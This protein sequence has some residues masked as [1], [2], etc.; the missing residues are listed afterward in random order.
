MPLLSVAQTPYIGYTPS[1]LEPGTT[2][3]VPVSGFD[4]INLATGSL[5]ISLPLLKI[6]GRGAAG[7]TMTLQVEKHWWVEA[8]PETDR[9]YYY[10]KDRL[11]TDAPL[12]KPVGLGPGLLVARQSKEIAPGATCNST[13]YAKTLTRLTFVAPDGSET[14]FV[15][16]IYNG[17]PRDMSGCNS[18]SRGTVW[19]STDGSAMTFISD[20]PIFD[21]PLNT[22]DLRTY[23]GRL[24]MRDG[25]FYKINS[26][27]LADEIRDRNGNRV[28]FQYDTS[29]RVTLIRDSINREVTVSYPSS[30]LI[31]I[32][33]KSS[34]DAIGNRDRTI[35]IDYTFPDNQWLR[36]GL[37]GPYTHAQAFPGYL[38][39][40]ATPIVPTGPAKVTLPDGRYYRFWYNAYG[41]V[42]RID[43]PT[44]GRYE[45]DWKAGYGAD[46]YGVLPLPQGIFREC[47]AYLN[48]SDT[49]SVEQTLYDRASASSPTVVRRVVPN[50]DPVIDIEVVKHYFHGD[51]T[52]AMSPLLPSGGYSAA[53]ANREYKT[54]YY[55]GGTLKRVVENNWDTRISYSWASFDPRVT[56]VTTTL[57]D[58]SPNLVSKV[59]HVYDDYNNTTITREY[60]FGS[61]SPGSLLRRTETTYLTTNPNQNNTNYATDT[62]IHIRS[63][64]VQVS[65]YDGGGTERA[66]TVFDYD[67]YSVYPLEGYSGLTMVQHDSAY[68]ANYQKRG[69]ATSVT[70]HAVIGSSTIVTRS[71]F[72]IGGN[73]IKIVDP[74]E[75]ATDFDFSDNFGGLQY[76]PLPRPIRLFDTRAPIPGFNACAYLNQPLLAGQELARQVAGV[77]CD[78][79]TIPANAQAIVGNA[80]VTDAMGSGFITL[81]PNGQPRPSVSNLNY[82]SGQTVPNAFTVSLG[83]DGMFRTF[84][85][86]TTHFIVDVTGYFAPP[87][88][89]GLYYHPLPRPIR[90][91]DTRAPIQGFA[92]CEY[93][94]QPL[95]ADAELVKQAR[96]TCDGITIPADAT[97]IVGNATVTGATGNGFI[98]LF[99]DGQPRPP[100]SNLNYTTGQTVPNA[101]TVGLGSNGQFRT[102]ASAGTHF[103]VDITGY[104]SPSPS[105]ANGAGLLYN[106]LPQ[107]IR[108]FDTRAPIQGFAACEYLDQPLVAD[109]ELVKQARITCDGITIPADAT[110]IVGNATV[111]GA[112]GNGF[113]TLF[114]DGQPRPPVSNLNYTTGQTVPNAFTVGLGSNGQFR[115]YAS[116]GTHFIV[117]LTGYFAPPYLPSGQYAFAFPTRTTNAVGHESF[118]QYDYYLGRPIHTQDANGVKTSTYYADALDRI[119]KQISAVGLPAQ[120][121]TFYTYDDA[122]RKVI[123]ETDQSATDDRRLKIVSKYDGLGRVT[124]TAKNEDGTNW[125]IIDTEYDGLGR[126]YRVSNP[127][128]STNYDTA[129]TPDETWTMTGFDGLGRLIS[130]QTPDGATSTLTYS[131]N[132]TTVQDPASRKRQMVADALGRV[133]SVV[134]DPGG[135]AEATTTYVYNVFDKVVQSTQTDGSDTQHRYWLYD[136]LSRLKAARYPEQ[137]APHSITDSVSGNNAWSNVYTYDE[138]GNVAEKLDPRSVTTYFE[139][140]DINRIIGTGYSDSTAGVS[141]HYDRPGLA[142]GKG[143]LDYAER[144]SSINGVGAA[145][146]KLVVDI[147]DPFGRVKKQTTWLSNNSETYQRS[148]PVEQTYNLAGQVTQIKYPS[149]RTVN[150]TFDQA[151]RVATMNGNLG[152][153]QSNYITAITYNPAHQPLKESWGTNT[154]LYLNRHYNNRLQNYDIRLGTSATD[155]WEWNRGALRYYYSSNY[156]WGDGGTGNNGNLYRAEHFIPLDAAVNEWVM[157]TQYYSYDAF[158]RLAQ[159]EEFSETWIGGSNSNTQA[160]KQ[161]YLYDNFG[162]RRVDDVNSVGLINKLKYD[163][164]KATNRVGVPS[165]QTGTITYDNAGNMVYDSYST[166][167]GS[168]NRQFDGSSRLTRSYDGGQV[169]YV[170]D[171]HGK[172]A[173]K[174]QASTS[175]ETWYIYGIGGELL[176]EYN[177]NTVATSPQREYAYKDGQLLIFAAVNEN[178]KWIVCDVLGTPRM[179]VDWW[180]DL[181]GS[182]GIQRHDYLPFGEELL[183]GVGVR[184]TGRGYPSASASGKGFTEQYHD[185]ETG[186]DYFGARYYNSIT[187]RFIS[188]DPYDA[189][190]QVAQP[191]GWNRYSYVRNQPTLHVDPDGMKPLRN[192]YRTAQEVLREVQRVANRV[193]ILVR[194]DRNARILQELAQHYQRNEGYI[195]S[196]RYGR[197]IDLNHFFNAAAET[198]APADLFGFRIPITDTAIVVSGLG[199][200]V[201]ATQGLAEVKVNVRKAIDDYLRDQLSPG[202]YEIVA[203]SL[204]EPIEYHNN[205]VGFGNS[206]FNREDLFS[207][208]E[209]INW[210]VLNARAQWERLFNY[211]RWLDIGSANESKEDMWENEKAR[212]A[213]LNKKRII[214]P[215]RRR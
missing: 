213:D 71:K 41:E 135:A 198:A 79:I 106:P 184:A 130:T 19:Y 86:A 45:Y 125:S 123:V 172:R 149:A 27:G 32:T 37:P 103:I 182:V 129:T 57:T 119:T 194:G 88:A 76:Y 70:R 42:A 98:T 111:T 92:A 211:L 72:D 28:T 39:P 134:L 185:S 196:R 193:P 65:V 89:G 190:S 24:M 9:T 52:A 116:A 144:R 53:L 31:Q 108:L 137:A 34:P 147:F 160:F 20:D 8:V 18:F 83:A 1:G 192:R 122:N 95:V 124:R 82:T 161:V 143:R 157:A 60:D 131:G 210:A 159:V 5:N 77:T 100:V 169:D 206:A 145:Y 84:S 61:G 13:V 121:Q 155:E 208:Q 191:Q 136:S 22:N 12:V 44:G 64:P 102:Y 99:P 109:A 101:F 67:N 162:N 90:L 195:Y 26:N 110:A 11:W 151:G 120:M 2:S 139:Y 29:R 14:T 127:Y 215:V 212:E 200:G 91:F 55:D 107:P 80:T 179:F 205:W 104:Y 132:A 133:T 30:T 154:A 6:G 51:P 126:A 209:G 73:L 183:A 140:D 58:V 171:V 33:Y 170:Y 153:Q 176:A 173:R 21:Q 94:D 207:N 46:Q 97:A 197:T 66:R 165:G 49:A 168:F 4:N 56:S 87:G 38:D 177:Y 75:K 203:N 174:R 62:S 69:N 93:L 50:T 59:E 25:T 3:S 138:N 167:G 48:T 180:G 201:E 156:A 63:L 10:P 188:A 142:Y 181:S 187:G 54:E 166:A 36:P 152:N 186:L 118:T 164:D 68:D 189:A 43:L 47:R 115:T 74:R 96:I 112:T 114:P 141:Y 105:D 81:F 178:I 85:S 40:D 163:I 17:Q 15:D 117:D 204:S 113:I 35:T 150:Y 7:Y 148:Y 146:S 16:A 158:N 199:L 78:G 128:R 175:T 214:L 23:S 202:A